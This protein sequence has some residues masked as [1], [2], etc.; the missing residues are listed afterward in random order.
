MHSFEVSL[1]YL[2]TLVVSLELSLPKVSILLLKLS[3]H[4][5]FGSL[6]SFFFFVNLSLDL[7]GLESCG[8]LLVGHASESIVFLFSPGCPLRFLLLP[9]LRSSFNHLNLSLNNG[10]VSLVVDVDDTVE[11]LA[12]LFFFLFFLV[13]NNTS[14]EHTFNQLFFVF[15]KD[16]IHV[17]ENL[18]VGVGEHLHGFK[19][20]IGE[21][22]V[23]IETKNQLTL[24]FALG[25]LLGPDL[26]PYHE[27][28]NSVLSLLGCC[29]GL[30]SF[31]HLVWGD[32]LLTEAHWLRR[33]KGWPLF[34]WS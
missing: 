2:R 8:D 30:T 13:R 4:S 19:D 25:Q 9:L 24:V 15:T 32:L 3:L 17:V 12:L 33:R 23:N 28:I 11:V 18:G 14:V 22:K 5:S 16:A 34:V 27:L 26:V 31:Y 21:M 10:W 7:P 1:I 20:A 29:F 6:S